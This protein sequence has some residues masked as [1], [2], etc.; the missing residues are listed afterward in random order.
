MFSSMNALT[1]SGT[2]IFSF[3]W[4]DSRISLQCA[5]LLITRPTITMVLVG[6]ISPMVM[7]KFDVCGMY[8]RNRRFEGISTFPCGHRN[9]L[10]KIRMSV[11]FKSERPEE[12]EARV[13]YKTAFYE[14]I[15]LFD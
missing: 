7:L 14:E 11:G 4:M 3:S 9:L 2:V 8:E 1:A 5:A 10:R 12:N 15:S 13:D 6:S